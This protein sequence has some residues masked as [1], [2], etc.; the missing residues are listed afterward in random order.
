MPDAP[1]LATRDPELIESFLR[2]VR[3]TIPLSIEQIEVILR[4]IAA[5]E[6]RVETYLDLGCGG[7]VIAPAVLDEYPAARALLLDSSSQ[8]LEATRRQLGS[9]DHRVVCHVAQFQ[10]ADWVRQA[11]ALAPFDLITSGVEIPLLPED[12]Q[13]DFFREVYGLLRPGG[14]LLT[15]EHV[16]SATRWTQ[17]PWDDRMI[18][19]IFGEVL[20]KDRHRP[21]TEIAREFYEQ[22]ARGHRV[23]PLEVQCDWLREIGFENV[24]CFLKIAEMAV[25]GGM[26]PL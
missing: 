14:F 17:S 5:A 4:L 26:K 21:R 19:A 20:E 9:R 25:F 23:A 3:G 16:A 12:R 18:E 6:E 8:H 24:E 2:N 22:I 13:Q 15:I 7:G 1:P 10:N 11:E